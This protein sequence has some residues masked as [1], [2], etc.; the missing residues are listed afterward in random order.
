MSDP[1]PGIALILSAPSGTGKSTL[2]SRLTSE[3]PRFTY[4]ISY[5]TRE[6]REGEQDGREYHF[7]S[8]EEFISLKG[9]GFFAEWAQVHGNY[10]GTPLETTRAILSQGKDLLFDIDVQGAFQLKENL[11][12]GCFV[13]LFPP[14]LPEL[15]RRLSRRGS[16]SEE[17]LR[18]RLKNAREEMEKAPFFDY[19]IVNDDLE[20]AYDD[21]RSVYL[22]EQKKAALQPGLVQRILSTWE[23]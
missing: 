17:V 2:V 13:F 12:Q 23:E 8:R 3:F 16:E 19:W 22:A 6:P 7:V 1:R 10:Y 18:T 14:S 15:R 20:R 5:T 4:S 11:G 9:Q 21:L